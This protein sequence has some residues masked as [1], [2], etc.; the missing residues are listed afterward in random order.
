MAAGVGMG[1]AEIFNSSPRHLFARV[2]GA[3]DR[4][5]RA[6]QR[7]WEAAR[8][9]SFYLIAPHDAKNKIKQPRDLVQF[10]WEADSV[11]EWE[12][13]PEMSDDTWERLSE[14]VANHYPMY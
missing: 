6:H 10:P 2:K 13:A 1:E 5:T 14:F 9:M 12:P 7:T 4:E 8:F 11:T 3:N